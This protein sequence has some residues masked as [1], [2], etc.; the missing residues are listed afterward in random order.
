MRVALVAESFLPSVNGVTESLLRSIRHLTARGH[1]AVVLAPTPTAE[2]HS[3]DD[4]SARA[5]APVVWLPA[6]SLPGYRTFRLAPVGVARV[7][8]LL[9]ELFP[10]VVHLA[11]PFLLGWDAV[12]AA[13]E[14]GLPTVAVYQT[15]VPRY[16]VHYGVGGLEPLLWRRVLDIHRRATVNLAPST[17]SIVQLHARG[18]LNLRRWARGVD[19]EQFCSARRDPS[20]RSQLSAG[21]KVIVG[22]AGRLAPE[23][24]LDD[25]SVLTDV[26]GVQ[27]VLIGDG[28][29]R[30][31][32]QRMLPGAVFL[33]WRHGIELARRVASLDVMVHPGERETF[34]QSVQ[35]AMA[36]GVPVVA[37]AAGGILDLVTDGVTGY[38][39]PIGALGRLRSSVIQLAGHPD[40]RAAMGAA[41]RAAVRAN[42]WADVGDQLI[43]HYH[44]AINLSRAP[45]TV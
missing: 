34:G 3:L 13:N 35:E 38:L 5:G 30:G 12:R 9:R 28:P 39:Y 20:F 44:D 40:R 15:D 11:S 32:L 37:V 22:Y 24:Q 45:L 8:T 23:K 10:D 7:R 36:A 43:T 17:S 14:L 1:E 26:T 27:L 41:A 33:G 25:L 31:Q 6:V 42:S 19:A 21:E 4:L 16:A 2:E 18:V 29:T